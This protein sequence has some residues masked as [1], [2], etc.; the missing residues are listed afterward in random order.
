ML[1]KHMSPHEQVD[2][3]FVVKF[4]K[5]IQEYSK[6]YMFQLRVGDTSGEIMLRYWGPDNKAD[7][8]KIYNSIQKDDIIHVVGETRM[9]NNRLVINV[10]P[11]EGRIT[12]LKEGE[13]DLSEFIPES[14]KD[15]SEMYDELKRVIESVNNAHT[16]R[17]LES[18]VSDHKFVEKF[19]KHPAAMYRHHGWLG[20]LLEHTLNVVKICDFFKKIHPELD[21]DLMITGAILHDI[22]KMKELNVTTSI[23]TSPEGML[24]GHLAM[25]FELV[26]RKME[27]IGTPENIKL[28][29]KHILLSHH[30]KMEHGSPKQPAIP[31]ALAVYLADLSDSKLT[32]MITHIKKART[33]DD[34]IY[35]SDLGPIYLR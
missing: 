24:I 18:F 12:V 31:E 30:G 9:F 1:I 21:R 3:R 23:K 11:P 17:L 25:T 16:K 34:Y 8:E 33:E 27:E 13:Y 2:G 32:E 29:I 22:G 10:N 28:K 7:V 6:G 26:S 19:K 15:P 4:K 20:G 35:I 14:D 5:P